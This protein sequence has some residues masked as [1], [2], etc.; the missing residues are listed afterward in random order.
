MTRDADA[1]ALEGA[2]PPHYTNLS[3]RYTKRVRSR[4]HPLVVRTRTRH[5]AS[6]FAFDSASSTRAVGSFT[7]PN[8]TSTSSEQHVV[9]V[10]NATSLFSKNA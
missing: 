9:V 5:L 6:P 10:R 1:L 3:R 4:V 8:H 2:R 7:F